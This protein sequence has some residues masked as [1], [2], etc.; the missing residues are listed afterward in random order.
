[1]SETSLGLYRSYGDS[2]VCFDINKNDLIWYY[3]VDYITNDSLEENSH[4]YKNMSYKEILAYVHTNLKE[5]SL[6]I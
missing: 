1:M 3:S 6:V 2:V 4:I 5:E